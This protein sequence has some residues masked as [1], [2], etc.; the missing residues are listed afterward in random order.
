MCIIIVAPKGK[1]IPNTELHRAYA[2]NPDGWGLAAKISRGRIEIVRGFDTQ[3]L[4]SA[5]AEYAGR[6]S[7]VVHAR[8]ATSGDVDFDNSHPYVLPGHGVIFHN[9]ILKDV[10]ETNP[11]KSDTWHYAE[12]LAAQLGVDPLGLTNPD[13]NR[14]VEA[15]AVK[16]SSRFVLM[17]LTEPLRIYNERSGLWADGMWYSNSS[18]FPYKA[19]AKNIVCAA[20][21]HNV[22][23]IVAEALASTSKKPTYGETRSDR[24]ARRRLNLL[25]QK[26]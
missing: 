12:E 4:V 20:G 8:I 24:K 22:K 17:S 23:T 13:F 11:T 7:I 18:A 15:R 6:A 19:T 2:S 26:V 3:D 21:L 9:G 14:A 16:N 10:A 1:I 5:Y 25:R